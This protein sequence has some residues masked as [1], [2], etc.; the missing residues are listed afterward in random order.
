[1]PLPGFQCKWCGTCINY[2]DCHLNPWNSPQKRVRWVHF[3]G[4]KGRVGSLELFLW[5]I[6]NEWT[7]Y[8]HPKPAEL[9]LAVHEAVSGPEWP[10]HVSVLRYGQCEGKWQQSDLWLL[11]YFFGSPPLMSTPSNLSSHSLVSSAF[12]SNE[13]LACSVKLPPPQLLAPEHR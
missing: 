2:T 12:S 13:P 11:F 9:L 4:R 7:G 8:V 1:M 5:G 10:W 6:S 3:K